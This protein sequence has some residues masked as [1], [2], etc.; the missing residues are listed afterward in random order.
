MCNI[1]Y[2][3]R[4]KK[5]KLKFNLSGLSM[6]SL[7]IWSSNSEACRIFPRAPPVSNR[8]ECNLG[9]LLVQSADASKFPPD[10][11][12]FPMPQMPD[13]QVHNFSDFYKAW[14]KNNIHYHFTCQSENVVYCISCCRC[15]YLFVKGTG[16][17]LQERFSEHRGFPE[18]EHLISASHSLDD[19]MVCGI[20]EQCSG[21]YISCKQHEMKLNF[22]LGCWDQ[23]DW[24]W[25]LELCP[26][27]L[28]LQQLFD[29]FKNLLSL[30]S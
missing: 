8:C 15:N 1:C 21:S 20:V 4:N 9:D 24:T 2:K 14:R 22:K 19:I 17:R 6:P 7:R 3:H 27:R 23:T 16:R 26:K 28:V 5:L 12:S 25:N 18:A 13:V 11:I 29:T 30:I 10:A